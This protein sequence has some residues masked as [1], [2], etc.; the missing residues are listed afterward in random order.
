MGCIV[1]FS[2]CVLLLDCS[3]CTQPA[4]SLDSLAQLASLQVLALQQCTLDA[5]SLEHLLST[6]TQGSA[7]E[8]KLGHCGLC[9]CKL[10]TTAVDSVRAK[11]AALRGSQNTPQVSVTCN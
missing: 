6:A 7:L 5:A 8:I 1:E 9:S 11:V 3:C 10:D 4:H 2:P